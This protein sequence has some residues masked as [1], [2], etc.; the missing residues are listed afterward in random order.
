MELAFQQIQQQLTSINIIKKPKNFLFS[1]SLNLK[2]S[3]CLITHNTTQTRASTL[4]CSALCSLKK[5]LKMSMNP[6]IA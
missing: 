5:A 1:L 4:N 2:M 3:V 6:K